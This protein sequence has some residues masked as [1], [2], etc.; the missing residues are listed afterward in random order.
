MAGFKL[1]PYKYK[2]DASIA[3]RDE[4]GPGR[5]FLMNLLYRFWSFFLRANFFRDM[6]NIFRFYAKEDAA[7]G[8]RY[9][10]ECLF[11][12]YSYYLEKHFDPILFNDF[13][14][15]TKTSNQFA[16]SFFSLFN[17]LWS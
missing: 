17:S 13:Q 2:F 12:F 11:R 6:Y 16:R 8:Y 10:L 3:E 7:A 9:G 14:V 4:L 1:V 15:R 5:S